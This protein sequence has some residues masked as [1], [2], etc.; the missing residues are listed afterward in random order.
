[1][2]LNSGKTKVDE[3]FLGRFQ[4]VINALLQEQDHI[5]AIQYIFLNLLK[6]KNEEQVEL[7]EH[8]NK[9]LVFLKPTAQAVKIEIIPPKKQIQKSFLN[10]SWF[11]QVI[12]NILMNAIDQIP[13]V[14]KV[15]GKIWIE[16]DFVEESDLPF[17][18]KVKDNGPGIHTAHFER[19]FEIFFTTK[20]GGSGLGLFISKALVESLGGKIGIRESI[21]FGGTTFLV[22]LPFRKKEGI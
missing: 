16:V 1:M 20:K 11:D 4:R 7:S 12:T 9:L 2:N 21:R 18:V 15:S 19:V 10:T 5:Q 22:E 17:K 13:L 14:R 6:E 8:L 3:K